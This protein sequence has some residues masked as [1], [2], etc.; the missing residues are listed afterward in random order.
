MLY[1]ITEFW[2]LNTYTVWSCPTMMEQLRTFQEPGVRYDFLWPKAHWWT[3]FSVP[4]LKKPG[5]DPVSKHWLQLEF[6]RPIWPLWGS[7]VP[8][9]LIPHRPIVLM[10]SPSAS[11]KFGLNMLKFFSMLNFLCILKIVL[12]YSKVR[13]LYINWLIWVYQTC[14]EYTLKI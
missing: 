8:C 5:Y 12:V 4:P 10:P 13:F 11:S 9:S 2:P 3:S 1:L 7:W 6:L 14:F